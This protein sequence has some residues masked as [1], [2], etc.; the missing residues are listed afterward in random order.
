MAGSFV[1][2]TLADFASFFQWDECRG[3]I[4]LDESIPY[5]VRVGQQCISV[6]GKNFKSISTPPPAQVD[7]EAGKAFTAIADFLKKLQTVVSSK[8]LHLTLEQPHLKVDFDLM[9]KDRRPLLHVIQ[10]WQTVPEECQTLLSREHDWEFLASKLGFFETLSMALQEP[11]VSDDA[12]SDL[13]GPCQQYVDTYLEQINTAL[14]G[15]GPSL[16]KDVQSFQ[17]KYEKIMDAAETWQLQP[18]EWMF[19]E[20][21][22]SNTCFDLESVRDNMETLRIHCQFLTAFIGHTTSHEKLKG[23]LER[24]LKFHKEGRALIK[25]ASKV[26][27]TL[28]VLGA[29]LTGEGSVDKGELKSALKACEE[30]FGTKRADLPKGLQKVAEDALAG[31]SIQAPEAKKK[32]TRKRKNDEDDG[33]DGQEKKSVKGSRGKKKE[34]EEKSEKKAKRAKK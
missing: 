29:I 20:G 22:E 3:E 2:T 7:S 15:V 30:D 27:G 5:G 34:Q 18:V 8:L 25:A 31:K 21:A 17:A 24:A 9:P 28:L 14:D 26:A 4:K 12:F 16:M 13:R 23:L 32:P 33:A 10:V 11:I 1:G 6:L 19:D